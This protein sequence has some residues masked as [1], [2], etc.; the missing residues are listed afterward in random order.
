MGEISTLG[1]LEM[2][3][4]TKGFW[5]HVK[6]YNLLGDPALRIYIP[7]DNINLQ[8]S[9]N[10]LLE[11]NQLIVTGS[12]PGHNDGSLTISAH[13]HFDSLVVSKEVTMQNGAFSIN[14]FKL[15]SQT[16]RAWSSKGGQGIVRAYFKK[17]N[18]EGASAVLFSVD[19]PFISGLYT[20]PE[21]P[22][23]LVPFYFIVNVKPGDLTATIGTVDSLMIRWTENQKTW[24]YLGLREQTT[25]FWKTYVALQ[26]SEGTAISY[27]VVALV[28]NQLITL[29]ETKNFQIGYRPDLFLDP[30][31]VKVYGETQTF[32]SAKVKNKGLTDSGP[33]MVSVYEAPDTSDLAKIAPSLTISG[34]TAG[35]ETVVAFIW[36]KSS[37]G[38][39]T[40]IFRVDENDQVDEQNEQNNRTTKNLKVATISQG[41]AGE[42]YSEKNHF[43]IKIPAGG[44]S[45]NTSIEL[46]EKQDQI[47]YK[48]AGLTNLTLIN[49]PGD[50]VWKA[51]EMSFAD[52]SIILN[53]PVTVAAFYDVNDSL[54]T[55]YLN[56]N[57]LK[58][59]VWNAE[60]NTWQGI[61]ST[62]NKQERYVL[63]S[64]PTECRTFGLMA[65][66]D[67]IAPSIKI[68]IEGQHFAEGDIISAHPAFTITAQDSSGFDIG[69]F[70]IQ[71]SLND[72]PVERDQI[73]L[74][75][76]TNTKGQVTATYSPELTA[77]EHRIK[78]EAQ[79]IN[80]NRGIQEV[81]FSVTGQFE[82][83]TIAN[84]PNPFIDETIIA[85]TLTD[86]AEEVSLN[87][88]TVSGR[89]IRS[90]E[91]VDLGGYV[92][93]D[94]D[95]LD[96]YGNEIANGVYYLKFS[97]KKGLTKIERIEKLAKLK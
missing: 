77:G 56:Q 67:V 94:W 66:S 58:I 7:E 8:L 34:L 14:L 61:E 33:F 2:V 65:S 96:S 41:T 82:L 89:L 44:V 20:Q 9:S 85:F 79:D 95:G 27:H 91:F 30:A 39:H 51:L 5:D 87:I 71:I 92:E 45:K 59:F 25:G 83:T 23:H 84:H 46:T 68:S 1:K 64:L 47:Y 63:A 11:N 6:S 24:N 74:F 3:K 81:S 76:E 12:V 32:I 35:T 40:I 43:Y 4:H 60:T 80:G 53:K 93:Q 90:F 48:T 72:L 10:T 69:I 37:P 26:K 86:L 17:G 54:T 36:Q 28:N 49:P 16:R 13:N 42:L 78:V 50:S 88:Y 15:D 18:A 62:I 55:L 22:A 29:S 31:S 70:P 73:R 75:Q 57:A 52:S 21:F 38:E 97:A 19:K